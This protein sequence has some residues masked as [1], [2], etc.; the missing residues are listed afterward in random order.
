MT[1]VGC[2]CGVV[3][4]GGS[5]GSA[6]CSGVNRQ[7]ATMV[8][9]TSIYSASFARPL[10]KKLKSLLITTTS[11]VILLL[12]SLA[13]I[14]KPDNHPSTR[15]FSLETLA[16]KDFIDARIASSSVSKRTE[17]SLRRACEA[18][19]VTETKLCLTWLA[20]LGGPRIGEQIGRRHRRIR[21]RSVPQPV[22]T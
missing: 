10:R 16:Q 18:A 13:A 22:P 1:S 8:N 4:V 12:Y 5:R 19:I 21:P 20:A 14:S 9:Q 2:V 15:S 17:S 3:S 11:S 7:L 6:G